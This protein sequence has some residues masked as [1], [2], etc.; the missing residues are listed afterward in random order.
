MLVLLRLLGHKIRQ[1]FVSRRLAQSVMRTDPSNRT[2]LS[3][4][5]ASD[6]HSPGMTFGRGLRNLFLFPIISIVRNEVMCDETMTIR[7]AS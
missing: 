1:A 4:R 3:A 5:A 2:A 6:S 7:L